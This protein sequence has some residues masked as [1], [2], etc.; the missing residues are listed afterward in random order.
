VVYPKASRPTLI[1]RKI[2]SPQPRE[3]LFP[4]VDLSENGICFI[5]DGS[6]G[7]LKEVQGSIRWNNGEMD[8][9]GGQIVRRLGKRV[10]IHLYDGFTWKRVLEEQRRLLTLKAH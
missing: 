6:L 10:S 5:D 7:S 8:R 9:I 1:V 3:L 4:I 2:N